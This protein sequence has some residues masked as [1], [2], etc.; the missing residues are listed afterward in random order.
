M[1]YWEY[2]NEIETFGKVQAVRGLGPIKVKLEKCLLKYCPKGRI[3]GIEN[4]H[5]IVSAFY[6]D[7]E[8]I[9]REVFLGYGYNNAYYRMENVKS[10]LLFL[11]WKS[12][13]STTQRNTV[14]CGF[15]GHVATHI[16]P[17]K[18]QTV[19]QSSWRNPRL[20]KTEGRMGNRTH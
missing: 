4:R 6:T 16:R 7:R 11:D 10:T 19:V 2:C 20:R 3:P 13:G 15:N 9:K 17:Q 8:N 18:R 1:K 5:L 14:L 12:L